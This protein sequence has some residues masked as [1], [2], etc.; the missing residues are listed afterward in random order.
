MNIILNGQ[1][2]D[3]PANSS[4]QRLVEHFTGEPSRVVAEVDGAIIT[5]DTWSTT[6]L[7]AGCRVEL[8]AFVGGG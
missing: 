2:K 7:K 8:V 5:R 1:N 6:A 4:L 3:I